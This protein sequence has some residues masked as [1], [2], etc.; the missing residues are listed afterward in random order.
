[1]IKETLKYATGL[2]KIWDKKT[3]AQLIFFVTNRCNSRCRHCFYWK[4]LNQKTD[5]LSLAEI[6]KISKSMG[7]IFWLFISGGEPFL[8]LDLPQICQTFYKN[9]HVNSIVIPT[10]GILIEKI[11]KDTEM[12]VKKCPQAKVVIQ[13]SIDEIGKRHDLLRGVRGNF[14]K[15]AKLIPLLKK[16]Q[17]KYANLAIQAN[18]VFMHDNQERVKE[19]YRFIYEEFKIDNICLSLIRGDPREVGTK[20]I[21]MEKY[22]QAHQ[23]LRKTKRFKQYTSILSRLITK[24]EDMQVEQFMCSLKDK[25]AG[26]PCLAGYQSVVL[27]PNGDLKICELRNEI[28]GNLREVNY[29]FSKLWQSQKAEKIRAKIKNCYCTQECVYTT[30]IFLNPKVWPKFGKYLLSGKL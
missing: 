20:E 1:M 27:L 30:N 18:I 5:E 3:P 11:I 2:A 4:N 19:I 12:I 22:W 7:R 6:E 16:L 9:N 28:F 21:D 24:K 29:Q 25:K 10:N 26:I 13:V 8:R 15:I 23:F 14:A 17:K